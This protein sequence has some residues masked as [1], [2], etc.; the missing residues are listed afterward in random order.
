MRRAGVVP[1][2]RRNAT[3]IRLASAIEHL[4]V[5]VR[6]RIAARKL[7]S[8]VSTSAVAECVEEIAPQA[9]EVHQGMRWRRP[10]IAPVSWFTGKEEDVEVGLV[11]FGKR[12]LNP[13]LGRWV[14]ADPLAVHEPGEADLN[15]Y[16]YVRGMALKAVDP[17]G[18]QEVT[19]ALE[20]GLPPPPGMERS[21]SSPTPV[22]TLPE[23]E[24]KGADSKL[25]AR[26][27]A[28]GNSP[29]VQEFM[30]N[31]PGVIQ[32][33]DVRGFGKGV[34]NSPAATVEGGCALVGLSCDLSKLKVPVARNEAGGAL[35]GEAVGPGPVAIAGKT[36]KLAGKLFER[37]S[38]LVKVTSWADKGM[39]P[40]LAPGRWVQLGES[41]G[42]SFLKTGLP[43]PKAY[44]KP[45]FRWASSQA[46]VTNSITAEVPAVSLSWPSGAEMWKGVLGQRK[47]NG[48]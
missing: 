40:D 9:R 17:L 6:P 45:A 4:R 34:V 48:P 5:H 39:T 16:A 42:W 30:E 24:V 21:G 36:L 23:V 14:S 7:A 20:T 15:L 12:F 32:R 18:L 10:K 43:G 27:N 13:L 29:D 2:A 38:E 47:F 31:R 11:Y 33:Q 1:K 46:D 35:I 22:V 3:N 37:T 41:T 28:Q 25:I 8:G 19:D 26:A 44:F